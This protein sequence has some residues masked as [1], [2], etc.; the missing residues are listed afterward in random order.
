MTMPFS[1]YMPA[2]LFQEDVDTDM[3][4]DL[5]KMTPKNR[6]D[7]LK[8]LGSLKDS[9][10]KKRLTIAQAQLKKALDENA[11]KYG[12]KKIGPEYERAINNLTEL[13]RM[14]IAV[15]VSKTGKG[16]GGDED[17]VEEG[18][19]FDGIRKELDKLRGR[20]KGHEKEDEI[21]RLMKL[22]AHEMDNGRGKARG[23]GKGPTPNET[24]EQTYARVSK[25]VDAEYKRVGKLIAGMK[26]EIEAG[27]KR[28]PKS[29]NVPIA[30]LGDISRMLYGIFGEQ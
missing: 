20:I 3:P 23:Y 11:E 4:Q 21:L 22:L 13:E 16:R 12:M 26:N 24:L 2:P 1:S 14:I 6:K 15:R 5:S 25:K 10:L 9:E 8:F 18:E 28:N 29:W 17:V 19:L 27:I 7:F 30:E